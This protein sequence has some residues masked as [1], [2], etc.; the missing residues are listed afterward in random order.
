M[1]HVRFLLSKWKQSGA[2]EACWAHNP[3][4]DGSK[5]SSANNPL[6]SDFERS[7][8][9]LKRVCHS[10]ILSASG[11]VVSYKIP[12]LVIRV[13]FPAGAGESQIAQRN[14]FVSQKCTAFCSVSEIYMVLYI[15]I[16]CTV[17]IIDRAGL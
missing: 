5:P 7:N 6:K 16:K 14:V 4:V 13:R 3:E 11:V 1:I 2:A 9:Y 8:I 15:T 12:I 10:L 17:N